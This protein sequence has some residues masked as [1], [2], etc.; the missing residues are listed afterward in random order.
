[1]ASLIGDLLLR[2][3]ADQVSWSTLKSTLE[4]TLDSIKDFG[5]QIDELS[6]DQASEGI[7][8]LIAG[9]GLAVGAVEGVTEAL[10]TF[11][12]AQDV[13][14]SFALLLGDAE[15]ADA[16]F[17]GLKETAQ[18]LA[19]PFSDLLSVAQRIAPQFEVGSQAM[20]DVLKASADA[21]AATGRSFTAV[22]DGLDRIAITGQLSTRQMQQF[23]VSIADI[24]DFMG[25]SVATATALIK[26]GGED[27]MDTVAAVTGA[28]EQ[29][30]G[31]AAELI[32]D[33]LSGQFKKLKNEV[34]FAFE[35]LGEHLAPLAAL[36]M[37]G[38][39]DAKPVLDAFVD[40]VVMIGT[41]F[42]SA[43]GPALSFFT[44]FDDVPKISIAMIELGTQIAL[45]GQI[46][47]ALITTAH[48]GV[49]AI[50][51]LA[52]LNFKQFAKDNV[53]AGQV[54]LDAWTKDLLAISDHADALEKKLSDIKIPV[55]GDTVGNEGAST[56][57]D[58]AANAAALE[59]QKAL[60][61]ELTKATQD[62]K[63]ADADYQT[64]LKAVFV[65]TLL[66][67]S[68]AE[69]KLRDATVNYT[70]ANNDEQNA[71][72]AVGVAMLAKAGNLRDLEDAYAKARSASQSAHLAE[73]E[74]SKTLALAKLQE[75]T[76]TKDL[77]A[78][79]D[80]IAAASRSAYTPAILDHQT[81]LDNVAAAEDR[82]REAVDNVKAAELNLQTVYSSGTAT[83][84]DLKAAE[85]TLAA[86]K[87]DLQAAT[88]GLT[89]ARR[90]E[91][92]SASLLLSI[93][94]E[95]DSGEK[96]AL[97]TKRLL[98]GAVIDITG[99]VAD[100]EKALDEAKAA[101]DR[102][103]A[104]ELALQTARDR[105][106]ATTT[107]LVDLLGKAKTA[108]DDAT[109]ADKKATDQQ[110]ILTSQYRV[111]GDALLI[112]KDQT[113]KYTDAQKDLVVALSAAG[114]ASHDVLQK[115]A[116]DAGAYLRTIQGLYDQ[117]V[118]SS[119]EL[120]DARINDLQRETDAAAAAGQTLT[121]NDQL[122]LARLKQERADFATD[123]VNKWGNL[124]TTIDGDVQ[125]LEKSMVHTLFTGS[126][127]F[128]DEAIQGLQAIGEAVVTSFVKPFEDAIAKLVAGAITDLLSG[129]GLGGILSSLSE[130]GSAAK[131]VFGGAASAAGGVT[132]GGFN[133]G[134][135]MP[136]DAGGGGATG[137]AGG[138]LSA[139]ITGMISA[140]TGVVSAV[141]GVISVF[142]NMHQETSLNAIEAN[143]RITA[144]LLGSAN[145]N[146][147]AAQDADNIKGWLKVT[148]QTLQN[149]L[150]WIS[151]FA[152]DGAAALIDDV[153]PQLAIMIT[154]L[155]SIDGKVGPGV[156]STNAYSDRAVT[157]AAAPASASP[158]QA[159]A[160]DLIAQK[161]TA[162]V[163]VFT[164]AIGTFGDTIEK[165]D[166]LN[167]ASAT[168]IKM[169]GQMVIDAGK[170][171]KDAA[172]QIGAAGMIAR[173]SITTAAYAIENA[174]QMFDSAGAAQQ[175]ATRQVV[176]S[177]SALAAQLA[178][179][180]SRP[181]VNVTVT[182]NTVSS[183]AD[184][185]KLG[186]AMT[187]ALK[188]AGL[189]M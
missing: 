85:D 145:A 171:I 111:S 112:L 13:R 29:R 144:I 160:G 189:Q 188:K 14:T 22:A 177:L 72:A 179:G 185:A 182:G 124:F 34:E 186:D 60:K 66:D 148:G 12:K 181:N 161:M 57:P 61:G 65:P 115:A 95:L 101:D 53:D 129:K 180:Q 141:T 48:A 153:V 184:A 175:A 39:L 47:G 147:T 146:N 3:G 31:G 159:A 88:A 6:F 33:N 5:K 97:A 172:D 154:T 75:T 90:D 138:L 42:A 10:E 84:K 23:G 26:K 86:T 120:R 71:A 43:A 98:Q 133:L 49:N 76:V 142:Q 100:Y 52:T 106:N 123:Q 2:V 89:Q 152:H 69:Q 64:Y 109:T 93:T 83:V 127:S 163:D 78:A 45:I 114:V 82:F 135:T 4:N 37:N 80:S 51:D 46:I 165:T 157:A 149:N 119:A 169:A 125:Q 128:K 7:G 62:L 122:T 59:N 27:A 32:A 170:M 18:E 158:S 54:V 41:G 9:L 67:V 92:V 130:I 132:G 44:A 118:A 17:Q 176:S 81:A 107:E 121:A 102:V 50:A 117:G 150:P 168:Q 134:S 140:V 79:E 166:D 15:A 103:A 167:E 110:A 126:G 96:Q 187:D 183:A 1:M 77:Q 105:G 20:N 40:G 178:S 113:G 94:K 139:G 68:T 24:A 19:I 87:R 56:K 8:E 131:S 99:A 151:Q 38:F 25:V 164:K 173:D 63:Q 155:Q 73:E 174:A 156:V 28:I 136:P 55:V 58:F 70:I 108:R 116:D 143:T 36:I 74:A 162:L 16:A 35:D 91:T 21:A 137:A 104:A 11:S 30:F